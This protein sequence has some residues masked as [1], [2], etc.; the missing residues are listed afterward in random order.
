VLEEGEGVV[1]VDSKDLDALKKEE[2]E[3]AVESD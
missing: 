1:E 3:E 2:L